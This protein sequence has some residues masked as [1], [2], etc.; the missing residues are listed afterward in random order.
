[1]NIISTSNWKYILTKINVGLIDFVLLLMNNV[2]TDTLS[3]PIRHLYG[4][5]DSID[6]NLVPKKS[7]K[8]LQEHENFQLS[9]VQ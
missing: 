9:I 7:E 5:L 3:C 2:R 6:M 4:S 8:Y 1:M